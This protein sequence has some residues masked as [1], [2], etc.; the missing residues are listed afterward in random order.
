MLLSEFSPGSHSLQNSP[1]NK[2]RAHEKF[3]QK[4][5]A[6]EKKGNRAHKERMS[7]NL[8]W[9]QKERDWVHKERV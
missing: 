5:Q 9:R 7:K 6:G 8:G 2:Q 3:H 4:R 1:A